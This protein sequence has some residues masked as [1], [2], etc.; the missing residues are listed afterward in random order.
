MKKK[1]LHLDIDEQ[2][3]AGS[4]AMND[5]E[6]IFLKK[7]YT[8]LPIRRF[9]KGGILGKIRNEFEFR[10]FLSLKR[11][12][13]LVIQHPLYIGNRYMKCLNW[14]KKIRGF[15]V[16]VIIHDLESLRKLFPEF[17]GLFV[18]LDKLMLETADVLIVHNKKM[19]KYLEQEH[20]IDQG[21]MVDLQVFDYLTD[22][23]PLENTEK[24]KNNRIVVAGNFAPEKS[25]YIYKLIE[26][27]GSLQFYIYGNNY[28]NKDQSEN[29]YYCGAYPAEELPGKMNGDYGLVWDGQS[30]DTCTGNTGNYV[31]YNNPHKVS[32]YIAAGIPVIIWKKAALAQFVLKEQ[33]GVLVENL[34]QLEGTLKMVSEE[35]Y[36]TMKQNVLKLSQCVRTGKFME[37]AC[38]QAEAMLEG[39]KNETEI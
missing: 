38:E 1:I 28:K 7:G 13:I 34:G 32:S 26:L 9:E 36:C 37:T 8:I 15:K 12:D 24:E 17:S 14:S 18:E 10:K 25:G 11:E 21:K 16:I 22:E 2:F 30:I 4:K 33:I 39:M 35:E 5:C 29:V 27:K 20:G 23:E 31:K 6:T 19:L 3:H